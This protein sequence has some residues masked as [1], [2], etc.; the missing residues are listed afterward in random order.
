MQQNR[1]V[2]AMIKTV[3]RPFVP[4]PLLRLYQSSRLMKN[5]AEQLVRG[6]EPEA[7]LLP[8]LCDR[9]RISIDVGGNIGAYALH[10][11]RLSR[12]CHVFEPF[13]GFATQ[14]KRAFM[15]D[16]RVRV[17]Q[18]ALSDRTGTATLRVPLYGGGAVV[19][20]ATIERGNEL[21]GLSVSS[22]DVPM[23]RLD[24]LHFRNVGFI[25]IDV[26][27]HEYAVLRG[28]ESTL[29]T[30]RPTVLVEAEERHSFGTIGRLTHWMGDLGYRGMFLH[31]GV[32]HE[33]E[34]FDVERYQPS[35]G[36]EVTNRR[37]GH[38]YVNNFIF[39]VEREGLRT[40]LD[41][42]LNAAQAA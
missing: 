10:I 18:V 20:L 1:C 15:F 12:M 11:R 29:R 9:D 41:A 16:R 5:A 37:P 32:M 6:D 3:V 14:L 35:D 23:R 24:D 28:A 13:P 7:M 39:T 31:D 8:A 34:N 30:S 33:I 40:R 22:V 36:V 4:K 25:K 38:T 21:Q 26:E 19:A 2:V 27:G 42:V 17:H